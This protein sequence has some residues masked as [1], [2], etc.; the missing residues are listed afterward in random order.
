MSAAAPVEA[1]PEKA[2]AA[3]E[4]Q[5]ASAAAHPQPL[6]NAATS[7]EPDS[8][9]PYPESVLP[10]DTL[11]KEP[12]CFFGHAGR[13]DE[14]LAIACVAEQDTFPET[15][16]DDQAAC[17]DI[18]ECLD[19][20]SKK[21]FD[22]DDLSSPSNATTSTATPAK[23]L[24]LAGDAKSPA[25]GA[26]VRPCQ[27][28]PLSR[29][30][31][32]MSDSAINQKLRRICAPRADGTYLVGSDWVDAWKDLVSGGRERVKGLF[33]KCAYDRDRVLQASV[34]KPL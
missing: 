1:C 23:P 9:W 16:V 4:Q 26:Q 10:D 27:E 13:D 19:T 12:A 25:A 17:L 14:A 21:A 20:P 28:A 32:V 22:E 34:F 31:P 6:P 7:Q 11:P 18:Y 8:A 33:E 24:Q 5:V 29:P 2:A 3:L 15:W 30:P